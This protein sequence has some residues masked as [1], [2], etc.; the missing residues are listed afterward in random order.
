[1][2]PFLSILVAS[3]SLVISKDSSLSSFWHDEA[4]IQRELAP[5]LVPPPALLRQLQHAPFRGGLEPAVDIPEGECQIVQ[6][7]VPQELKGILCR[8]GPGR[9]RLPSSDDN[10]SLQQYGHWF[11]GDGYVTKLTLRGDG[12]AT[13]MAKYVQTDRYVAQQHMDKESSTSRRGFAKAGAWTARGK[14]KWWQNLFQIPTNP[15]N[16]N[17]IFTRNNNNNKESGQD[18]VCLYAIAEG[19]DPVPLDMETLATTGPVKPWTSVDGA[20]QTQ[21]FFSA[22]PSRDFRTGEIYNH[23]VR[24]GPKGVLNLMKFSAD[25]NLSLQKSHA[26]PFLTFLHDSVVSERYMVLLLQPFGTTPSALL[27]LVLGRQ[28]L[29]QQLEWN[30]SKFGQDSIVLVYAK[31]TLECVA[32]VPCGSVSAYHLLDAFEKTDDNNTLTLRLLSHT[33][34]DIRNQLEDCFKDLYSAEQVPACEIREIVMDLSTQTV[35]QNRRIVPDALP[36]EL[37]DTNGDWPSFRKQYAY[38]NVRGTDDIFL[39][40]IQKVNLETGQTS[41]AV[42]FGRNTFAG[43]PLFVGKPNPN[44]EDDGYVFVQIYRAD[45]HQTDIVILDAQSMQLVT[46][47]RLSNH[48]PFQFHGAWCSFT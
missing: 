39:N 12:K 18:E 23:G 2:H 45:D 10:D 26:L 29:G 8:N 42:S 20:Q 17:V 35:A 40:Q 28:P 1:M 30:T 38:L 21:S 9:I 16:T 15:A 32:Q 5:S 37:P 41:E 22:H 47:L 31:D 14:G 19:G 13:F 48:V 6:G 43:A 27:D 7:K 33:P 24:L 3:S 44:T 25:G 11:D 46:R 4:R 34:L 36:C